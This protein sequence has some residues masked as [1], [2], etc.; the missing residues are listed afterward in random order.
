M[1]ADRQHGA[2][3]TFT[4]L[5]YGLIKDTVLV[6][7]PYEGV[8]YVDGSPIG[9]GIWGHYH[10]D[11]APLMVRPKSNNQFYILHTGE[12]GDQ[13]ATRTLSVLAYYRPRRATL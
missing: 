7:D 5:G 9:D 1:P 11:G 4:P 2:F 3:R 6:D 13:F 10:A 8:T 12:T